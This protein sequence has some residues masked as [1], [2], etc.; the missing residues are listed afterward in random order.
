MIKQIIIDPQNSDFYE[1]VD[2]KSKLNAC[3]MYK[4]RLVQMKDLGGPSD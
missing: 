2:H 4:L 3:N 1:L